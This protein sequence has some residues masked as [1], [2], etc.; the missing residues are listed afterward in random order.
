MSGVRTKSGTTKRTLTDKAFLVLGRKHFAEDFPNPGRL[1]C[2]KDRVLKHA[3]KQPGQMTEEV[4]NHI[5]LCSPCYNIFSG[6][7]RQAKP[8]DSPTKRGTRSAKRSRL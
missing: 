1:G 7:L 2:P 5:T 6:F 4:L 8:Q 3:A